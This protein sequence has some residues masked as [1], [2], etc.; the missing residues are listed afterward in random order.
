MIRF[1]VTGCLAMALASPATAQKVPPHMFDYG[2][3]VVLDSGSDFPEVWLWKNSTV[4]TKGHE[5]IAERLK[6]GE[7]IDPSWAASVTNCIVPKGTEANII[8]QQGIWTTV[9][10]DDPDCHGEVLTQEVHM[11]KKAKTP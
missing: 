5:I 7:G 11:K 6:R 9:E 1:V 2:D 8:I 3:R 10:T 4:M